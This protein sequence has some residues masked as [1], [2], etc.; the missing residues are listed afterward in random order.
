MAIIFAV[1]VSDLALLVVPPSSSVE[2][3][4]EELQDIGVDARKFDLRSG[5][6]FGFGERSEE[7]GEGEK[8]GPGPVLLVAAPATTRGVDLPYLTHVFVLG[9]PDLGEAAVFKH[10]AGRVDRFG[11]G[12]KVIT[13]L[14]EREE[15]VVD[16]VLRTMRNPA[17]LMKAF[18]RQLGIRPVDFDFSRLSMPS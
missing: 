3:T 18:Y 11:R 2:K 12:G 15:G 14:E 1:E 9:V 5:G 6:M 10:I 13:L 8:R 16:G 7:R 17:G 4:V